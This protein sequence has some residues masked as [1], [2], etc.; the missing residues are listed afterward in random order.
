MSGRGNSHQSRAG[1]AGVLAAG[2]TRA[3]CSLYL[4]FVNGFGRRNSGKFPVV[5]LLF[6]HGLE[7]MARG[8][9]ARKRERERVRAREQQPAEG[10]SALPATQGPG[11][12]AGTRLC[13]A[14]TCLLLTS[15]LCCS[16]G[17]TRDRC[18]KSRRMQR[19][20]RK[21]RGLEQNRSSRESP[22]Q[23]DF[24]PEPRAC[25]VARLGPAHPIPFSPHLLPFLC[26]SVLAIRL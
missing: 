2:H 5:K 9:R 8:E 14:D 11:H 19:V 13:C 23:R 22:A 7:G 12:V 3:A 26:L 17:P 15:S 1:P 20:P 21:W 6:G 25:P 10:C 24:W 18:P 16:S 4:D